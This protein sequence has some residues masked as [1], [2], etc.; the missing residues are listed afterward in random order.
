[1]AYLDG[2]SRSLAVKCPAEK[3]IT[4]NSVS[5]GLTETDLLAQALT[6]DMK[7]AALVAQGSIAAKKYG[8]LE[9][10]AEIVSFLASDD[11]R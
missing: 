1:M 6:G 9:D 11:A 7:L 8:T 10:F 2:I 3:K 5:P 4:T